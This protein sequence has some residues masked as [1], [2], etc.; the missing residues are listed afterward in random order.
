MDGWFEGRAQVC[1]A[2]AA[3]EKW[4]ADPDNKD[5]APGSLVYVV[6]TRDEESVPPGSADGAD[7]EQHEAG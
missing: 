7:H 3:A 1:F 6:D 2:K 5:A 4:R